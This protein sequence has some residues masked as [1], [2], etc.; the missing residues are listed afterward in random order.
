MVQV[1]LPGVVVDQ[2]IKLLV[3]V[4]KCDSPLLLSKETM[5][6]LDKSID[7]GTGS[8]SVLGK[9]INLMSTRSGHYCIPLSPFVREDINI[10]RELK[11]KTSDEKKNSAIKLHQQFC[12]AS[13]E[14]L[15][16]LLLQAGI[17]DQ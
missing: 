4:V 12:H 16:K 14:K 1:K 2:H 17:G 5:K 7:F 13:F 3:N 8:A 10:D 11:K 15:K 6:R 9:A